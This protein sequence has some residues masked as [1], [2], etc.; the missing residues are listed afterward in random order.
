MYS[1]LWNNTSIFAYNKNKKSVY[2][3]PSA[4]T[5]SFTSAGVHVRDLPLPNV[6][7]RA[8]RPGLRAIH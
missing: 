7:R 4:S 6:S 5:I 8:V 2:G 1:T 3:S